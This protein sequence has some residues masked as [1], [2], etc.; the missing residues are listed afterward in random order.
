[1][2]DVQISLSESQFQAMLD[3]YN[4]EDMRRQR[5]TQ[6]EIEKLAEKVN[7]EI[8]IPLIG[9]R[10]EGKILLK[11][12]LKIDRFLYNNL[13]N[14]IYDLVRSLEDGIS[15]KEAKNLVKRLSK[16]ANREINI[17]Y[18]PELLEKQLFIFIIALIINAMRNSWN[19]EKSCEKITKSDTPKNTD[20][21]QALEN[22]IVNK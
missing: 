15:D 18:V 3:D 1:M 22:S 17:P 10:K 13:P 8:D 20:D 11:I 14:E 12:I 19:I 9:E 16:L 21:D 5:M 4:A 2:P 6:S 7:K